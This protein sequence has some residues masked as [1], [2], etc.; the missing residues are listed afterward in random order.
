M[1]GLLTRAA[2]TYKAARFY[3]GPVGATWAALGSLYG[4]GRFG[5]LG[6][7]WVS[8]LA[9]RQ[10]FDVNRSAGNPLFNGVVTICLGVIVDN[11]CEPYLEVVERTPQGTWEPIPDHPLVTLLEAPNPVDDLHTI[12]AA[13]VACFCTEGLGY[14]VKVRDGLGRVANLEYVSPERIRPVSESPYEAVSYY[15][16]QVGEYRKRYAPEDVIVW[17]NER[18][19]DNPLLGRSRLKSLLL[20]IATDNEASRY[21]AAIL[22][23]MGVVGGILTM[24]N[25]EDAALMNEA[26][27]EKLQSRW[28]DV[29]MGKNRGGLMVPTFQADFQDVGRSPE[30]MALDVI[31]QIPE[32]RIAAALRVPAMVAGLTSAKESK[33]YANYAEARESFYEDCLIPL[34]RRF[35]AGLTRYLL[36]EFPG[37][38][39]GKQRV[40]WNYDGVRVLQ[41]DEDKRSVRHLAEWQA[42]LLTLNQTLE[43]IGDKP[44]EDERLGGAYFSTHQG[45]LKA[46]FAPKMTEAAGVGSS[47]SAGEEE[48]DNAAGKTPPFGRKAFDLP[49]MAVKYPDQPRDEDGKFARGKL[50]NDPHTQAAGVPESMALPVEKRLELA[51]QYVAQIPEAERAE[52][53]AAEAAWAEGRDTNVLHRDAAGNFN[54]ERAALHASI[55]SRPEYFG[56][57]RGVP[58]KGVSPEVVV[59]AGAP[60]SGKG[61]ALRSEYDPNRYVVLNPDDFKEHLPEYNGRNAP[62]V[63]AEASHL[64]DQALAIARDQRR[65]IVIDVTLR[66]AK[67]W[68]ATIA[69]MQS[70][71]YQTRGLHVG[72]PLEANLQRALGRYQKQGR[73]VP[74]PMIARE[75]NDYQ[76]AFPELVR[77]QRF[78]VWAKYDNGKAQ[79]VKIAEG[80]H[81]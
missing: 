9:S 8:D 10:G 65:N 54:P 19:P 56:G 26:K 59:L 39:P 55:L 62:L 37:Y 24:K 38:K 43:K 75:Y 28:Q 7:P 52:I 14:Y 81:E 47:D 22:H 18:D 74:L 46:E 35:A 67:W 21:T 61:T 64:M 12:A 44:L 66:D 33:S 49:G 51:Q 25:P 3:H 32:A 68:G 72:V 27:A 80:S 63:H 57:A 1:A 11:F 79:A 60:A 45:R 20:E 36:P 77:Q 5:Q 17:R 34:Q 76:T 42:D 4:W 29:T 6:D 40:Q 78:Q 31:R 16:Y 73:Y 70:E 50:S 69:A 71:G 48:A 58:E 2:H 23:N 41:P 53:G 30:E 15:L 13:W